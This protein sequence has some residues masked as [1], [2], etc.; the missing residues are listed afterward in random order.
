M[1]DESQYRYHGPEAN[2]EVRAAAGAEPSRERTLR[3]IRQAWMF[4]RV[5]PSGHFKKRCM[6]RSFSMLDVQRVIESGS[7]RGKPERC[8]EFGNLKCR[9]IGQV[10]ERRLEI[11]L[12]LDPAEDYSVSPLVILITG[13]WHK[14]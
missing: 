3:I 5:H 6:E 14:K 1:A 2:R 7:M 4:G 12:A 9:L 10:E 13:Y 11:V 8:T